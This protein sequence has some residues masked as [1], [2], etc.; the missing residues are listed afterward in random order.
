[1][2]RNLPQFAFLPKIF[3]FALVALSLAWLPNLGKTWGAQCLAA[4]ATLSG[5]TSIGQETKEEEYIESRHFPKKGKYLDWIEANKLNNRGIL[6]A[7]SRKYSQAIPYFQQAIQHYEHDFSYYEN[8]GAALQKTGN[9]ERARTATEQATQM[10]PKRWGP[11]YNLGLILTKEHEYGRAL[12]VL[13]KAKSLKVP[14]SKAIGMNKLIASL[15]KIIHQNE[16]NENSTAG[17]SQ[18]NSI[19]AEKANQGITPASE[20][21]NTTALDAKTEESAVNS[22]PQAAETNNNSAQQSKETT[23]PEPNM[24]PEVSPIPEISPDLI[25]K[26]N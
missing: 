21:E 14:A 18:Q 7:R 22:T 13:K 16:S 15:E 24:V 12:S 3:V 23:T 4:T 10:A 9:L 19:S 26:G 25:Q 17:E 5:K 20:K 2:N 1:M 6:L 8:L 11:W